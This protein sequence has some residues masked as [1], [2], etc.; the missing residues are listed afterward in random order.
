[1]DS[2]LKKS[3]I[4]NAIDNAKIITFDV[5]DTLLGRSSAL[6]PTDTFY[7]LAK[8]LGMTEEKALLFKKCRIEAEQLARNKS[9]MKYGHS[10]VSIKDIYDNLDGVFDLN[11]EIE[12]EIRDFYARPLQKELYEYAKS[13]GKKI[14]VI[15][16]IYFD[17]EILSYI[18]SKFGFV[19]DGVYSSCDYKVGK[20]NRKLYDKFL[21]ENNFSSEDV[22]HVGDNYQSDIVNSSYFGIKSIHLPKAIDGLFRA[23]DLNLGSI[24]ILH[25]KINTPF[26]RYVL[27]Y[28]AK[29]R[30]YSFEQTAATI[31]AVLYAAPLLFY[32]IGFLK[33]LSEK[34]KVDCLFLMARDGYILKDIL[35]VVD[36]GVSYKILEC[37]R[38]SVLIPSAKHN[39]N[40]WRNIFTS[41]EHLKLSEVIDGL[42]LEEGEEIKNRASQ[43]MGDKECLAGINSNIVE[44]FLK[45]SYKIAEPQINKEYLA[46]QSYFESIGLMK[47]DVSVVDVGWSLSSHKAIESLIGKK[48]AGYYIGTTANAYTHSDIFGYLFHREDDSVWSHIFHHAVE[49]LELPFIATEKQAIAYSNEGI[50]YRNADSIEFMRLLFAQEMREELKEIFIN[51]NKLKIWSQDI[52]EVS[53]V[54]GLRDLFFQLTFHPTLSEKILIG[55]IPH[56]RHISAAGYSTVADYWNVNGVLAKKKLSI[57]KLWRVLNRDG[58]KVVIYKLW[59][60]IRLSLKKRI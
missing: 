23:S 19:F 31:F 51:V 7:Y 46:A 1:M 49:L 30:E 45:E 21:T 57:S 32:F 35:D 26:S 22:L 60:L 25:H 4:F 52:K 3:V 43:L 39:Y 42:F 11:Q 59:L 33:V 40:V 47:K 37:S 14:Y 2:L 10:E 24:Y 41:A 38:R 20:Y 56:D 12:F 50:I 54:S 55:S 29:K 48:L 6:E 5:F 15:S 58:L 13:I 8:S 28:L 18:L 53:Q 36:V 9:L 27:A 34:N 17:K 16:D 44:K